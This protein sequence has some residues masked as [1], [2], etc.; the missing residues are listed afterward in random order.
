MCGDIQR[1]TMNELLGEDALTIRA[2]VLEL[3]H[4]GS[5]HAVA[6]KFVRRVEPRVVMQ[7]TGWTRWSRDKWAAALQ[8]KERLVTARDGACWVEIGPD[9]A[10]STGRFIGN[11]EPQG[12]GV[13]PK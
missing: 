5:H 13:S 11:A 6:E 12:S 8:G 4:H 10:I 3:P 7:S 2:D 1:K 9:G